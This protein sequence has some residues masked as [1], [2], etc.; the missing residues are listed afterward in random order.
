M[1]W[2]CYW[3]WCHNFVAGVGAYSDSK[4]N[5]YIRQEISNFIQKV[6]GQPSNPNNIF[7]SNGA[8][9]CVRMLL[10]AMIRGKTDGILV[11][12][13]QYPLY[14]ASIALYGGS[15]VP[16][17]LEEDEGWGLNM[18]EL[19]KSVDDARNKGILCRALVFINPGN[20]TGACLS[21]ENLID[22]AKF[23]YDNRLVMCADEVYQENIYTE[24]KFHSCR[25][26][27]GDLPEPYKSGIELVSFHTVSKG[28]YGECGLRGGYM[29]LHNFDPAVIDE[30]YKTAS[31]NLSPNTP[32][33]VAMGLMVNPPQP[34][35]YSYDA[36][37]KDKDS[38][39]QS[40][41][42]RAR[43]MTDAFNDLEGK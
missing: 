8:S 41:K 16:Y 10:F 20:P 39:L 2:F 32:G 24:K 26:V 23:C 3:L 13:P 38:V 42:R 15:L 31:I 18:E 28:A 34:G 37:I 43:R 27:I 14:S 1:I 12:I 33:Q 30:I 19:Q 35:D 40:L 7:I 11:P 25:K 21:E 17:F 4:G 6:S 36:F 5:L 9:E 22:L 29:E